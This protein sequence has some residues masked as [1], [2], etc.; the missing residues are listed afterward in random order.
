MKVI[1]RKSEV[2]PIIDEC[3]LSYRQGGIHQCVENLHALLL[4]KHVKFPLLDHCGY[5]LY[6][7]TPLEKHV[8][9]CNGIERLKTEGGNVLL[10]TIL[11]RRLEDHFEESIQKA[12]DYISVADF[13][14]T[15]DVIGERV[16]GASLLREPEK[17]IGIIEPLFSSEC[18]LVIRSL[19]AGIHYAIKK[20]LS[21]E[22]VRILFNFLLAAGK[23]ED[24]EIRQGIGWAAKTTAKFHPKI[25]ESY[26]V[27]INDPQKVDSWFR[28]KIGSGQQPVEEDEEE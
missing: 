1:S 12:V 14:Y 20:G 8:E 15:P 23:S 25:I 10:G 28:A 4:K 9:L 21:E 7:N 3:I 24:K 5:E 19:G 16:F 17:T 13:G 6:L 27:R 11:Q 18:S 2:Q 26:T 22:F